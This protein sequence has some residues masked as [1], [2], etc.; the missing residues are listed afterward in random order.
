MAYF[1]NI[2]INVCYKTALECEE[3]EHSITTRESTA[4]NDLLGFLT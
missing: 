2:T 1:K 3:R 4:S